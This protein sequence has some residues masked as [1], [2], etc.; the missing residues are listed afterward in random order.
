MTR[1][2]G[3]FF[4]NNAKDRPLGRS[5]QSKM[6]LN[7]PL[8]IRIQRAEMVDPHCLRIRKQIERTAVGTSKTMFF[9]HNIRPA[10]DGTDGF[11]NPL[12][13]PEGQCRQPCERLQILK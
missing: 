8:F 10:A 11:V 12:A 5:L 1:K 13:G 6:I 4:P 3:D 9:P 7:I 2:R